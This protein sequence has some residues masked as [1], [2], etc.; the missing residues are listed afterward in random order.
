MHSSIESDLSQ[1]TTSND[2]QNKSGER[3]GQ[4]DERGEGH[5]NMVSGTYQ[6]IEH[7]QVEGYLQVLGINLFVFTCIY[8]CK[9]IYRIHTENILISSFSY[10]D[11]MHRSFSH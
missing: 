5:M 2:T 8:I 9:Y 3:E 7:Q 11:V 6:V 4:Q 1:N 10:K